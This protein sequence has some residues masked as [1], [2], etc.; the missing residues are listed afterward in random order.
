ML[1]EASGHQDSIYMAGDA[2]YC[3]AKDAEWRHEPKFDLSLL[4]H[5]CDDWKGWFDGEIEMDE[6]EELGRGYRAMVSDAIKEA[7]VI[8]VRDGKGYIWDGWH[9][10]GATFK[11]GAATINA[12]VGNPQP[13]EV[14]AICR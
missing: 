8:L 2:G 13:A 12:I 3:Q 7:V 11:K 4:A 6:D 5:L 14:P 1:A 9:R 10:T